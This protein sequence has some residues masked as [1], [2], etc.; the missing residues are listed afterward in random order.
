MK[1]C[2]RI[3]KP[4]CGSNGRT[5]PNE[6][7][8]ENAKCKDR[9]LAI[10]NYFSCQDDVTKA[11]QPQ[12]T[13]SGKIKLKPEAPRTLV[14]G[15]CIRVEFRENIAC[16]EPVGGE[17]GGEGASCDVPV[18][19]SIK[20]FD[21]KLNQDGSIDYVIKISQ[22]L[23][24]SSSINIDST[25]NVGWCKKSNSNWLRDGDF[26]MT[27]SSIV[28]VDPKTSDYTEDIELEKYIKKGEIDL[29][30]LFFCL[31]YSETIY[32]CIYKYGKI[33][34]RVFIVIPLLLS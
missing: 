10:K 5:Y 24:K 9:S 18:L 15:S 31:C 2:Q 3:H 27:T 22:S 23:V 30:H 29:I 6:C 1:P 21:P 17:E 11:Q 4:V 32:S 26:I 16:D 33:T 34:D 12:Y 20:V 19:A 13:I 14:A 25:L 7:E 28:D 8:F